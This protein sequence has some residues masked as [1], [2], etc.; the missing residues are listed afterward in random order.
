MVPA[1]GALFEARDAAHKRAAGMPFIPHSHTSASAYRKICINGKQLSIRLLKASN[2][3]CQL[4]CIS[5][6]VKVNIKSLK[7]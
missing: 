6:N 7:R 1:A 3:L 5:H 4:T 2:S